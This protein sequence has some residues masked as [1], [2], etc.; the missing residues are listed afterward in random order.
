[1]AVLFVLVLLCV[2]PAAPQDTES[3]TEA[4]RTDLTGKMF[5]LMKS[6][7]G[8]VVFRSSPNTNI[9]AFTVCLRHLSETD[10]TLFTMNINSS[11]R[12][13]LRS[14][15]VYPRYAFDIGGQMLR[16]S[17]NVPYNHYPYWT[18]VCATWESFGGMAQVWANGLGSVRKA[19]W[20]GGIFGGQ[21]FLTLGDFEGQVTDVHMWDYELST[22]KIRAFMAGMSFRQGTVVSW[23]SARYSASGDVVLEDRRS[24]DVRRRARD[25]G[26]ELGTERMTGEGKRR[27]RKK[28]RAKGCEK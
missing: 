24:N 16:S 14:Q 20:R 12:F 7:S 10:Q 6:N 28:G 8:T 3:Q 18:D 13:S 25:E 27:R 15:S 1:M 2:W 17:L 22:N 26:W 21:V 23:T 4:S 9:S 19:A 11:A 5:S